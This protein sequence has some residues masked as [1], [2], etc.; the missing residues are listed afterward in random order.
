MTVITKYNNHTYRIYDVD[1]SINPSSTFS[2]NRGEETV[3]ISYQEYYYTKYN[4]RLS[5]ATQ[6]MLLTR[7]KQKQRNADQGDFICL[8]PELCYPTGI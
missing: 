3:T 1:F 4:I 7:A 2:K 8:V 6:P 5:S